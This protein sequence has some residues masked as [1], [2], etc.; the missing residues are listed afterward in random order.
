MRYEVHP[1]KVARSSKDTRDRVGGLDVQ[2]VVSQVAQIKL[3]NDNLS[4]HV[5]QKVGQ[6]NQRSKAKGD[7]GLAGKKGEPGAPDMK[8]GGNHLLHCCEAYIAGRS[9]LKPLRRPDGL[10][11]RFEMEAICRRM[12]V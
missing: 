5:R 2:Q 9:P 10:D 6:G 4:T 8:R 3:A 7:R 12:F 1:D 11:I